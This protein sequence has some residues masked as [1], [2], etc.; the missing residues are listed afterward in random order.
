VFTD[1]DLRRHIRDANLLSQPVREVMTVGGFSVT[2]DAQASS[3]VR[4]MED[5]RIGELPV[6]DAEGKL[7]GHVAL[8]DLLSMHFV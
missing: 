2:E 3:A 8:K 7:R 6:V 5:H 1:G 4:L